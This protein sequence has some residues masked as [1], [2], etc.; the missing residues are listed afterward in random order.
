MKKD[1]KL[2]SIYFPF[3]ALI[4]LNW[5]SF[6]L[7]LPINLAV[8]ALLHFLILHFSKVENKKA[9]LK[10]TVLP[11]FGFGLLAD[12]CGVF[13]RFLPRISTASDPGNC[14]SYMSIR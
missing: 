4:M 14:P 8:T 2:R 5:K 3:Y 11:S 12:L 10:Q 1:V 6:L 9:I 7:M 13:F